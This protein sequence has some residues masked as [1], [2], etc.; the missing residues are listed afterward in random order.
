[1]SDWKI[2]TYDEDDNIIESFVVENR[3][4]K[5]VEREAMHSVE[6]RNSSDWSM[7]EVQCDTR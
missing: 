6:V 1:M 5:E 2:T 4:E 7:K 3:T